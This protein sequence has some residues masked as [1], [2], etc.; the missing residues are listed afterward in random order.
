MFTFLRSIHID[1]LSFWL[2]FIAATIFWWVARS[3]RGYWPTL[4]QYV[5][6]RLEIMRQR[7]LSGLE[8]RLRR[9]TIRRAQGSHLAWSLFALDEILVEPRI[10]APPP[11]IEPG[12]AQPPDEIL[13]GTLAYL[14]DWTEMPAR[15]GAATIDLEDCLAG[16]ANIAVTGQPGSGKTVVLACIA[17]RIAAGKIIAP[18][19]E[20][21][22]PIYLHASDLSLTDLVATDPLAPIVDIYTKISPS[23]LLSQIPG[24][25]RTAVKTG[26][27]CF[28]LD[29]LDELPPAHFQSMVEYIRMVMEAYPGHRWVISASDE[30]HSGLAQLGFLPVSVASW[31]EAQYFQFVGQWSRLWM[32]IVLPKVLHQDP[33]QA[34]SPM[35]LNNWLLTQNEHRTPFEFTLKVWAAYGGDPRGLRP[36]DAIE[37]YLHRIAPKEKVRLAIER[38]AVQMISTGQVTINRGKAGSLVAEFEL[39]STPNPAE[40]AEPPPTDLP[41]PKNV[42]PSTLPPASP[43]IAKAASISRILPDLI[44]NGLIT[45]RLNETLGFMHPVILGYLA[46]CALQQGGNPAALVAQPSWIGRDL[47]LR[48]LAGQGSVANLAGSMLQDL[49]E[50]LFRNL[51]VVARWLKGSPQDAPWRGMVMRKLAEV[52][53]RELLPISVRQRALAAL[54]STNDSGLY[55]LFRQY[56]SSPS[57]SLRKLG[58]LGCGALQDQKSVAEICPLIEDEDPRVS[59]TAILVLA[60]LGTPSGLEAIL[61]VLMHGNEDMRRAVAEALARVPSIG[62]PILKEAATSQDILVR[63]ASVFGLIQVDA[64][65]ANNILE[66]MRVEDGQW[67]VRSAASQALETAQ[68]ANPRIPRPLPPPSQSPWLITYASKQGIGIS[69]GSEPTDMILEALK[70]G[71]EE[72][73]LAA[74]DYLRNKSEESI[75]GAILYAAYTETEPVREAAANALWW[76]AANGGAIPSPKKFGLS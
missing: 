37:A 73:K 27:V 62:H 68:Q 45:E 66:K 30:N 75:T 70:K 13:T 56:L 28:V 51:F 63:R 76:I 74:L 7:R 31:N 19:L 49:E 25:I 10:L 15:F 69:P 36:V 24:F 2:G 14:P 26:Q 8:G 48:Y 23:V 43:E 52:A 44:E 32:E 29:G 42:D 18:G 6:D 46:G 20:K 53:Q 58:A 40:V 65:W 71:T 5:K 72:E 35:L 50:P 4:R 33:S 38:L 61:S 3:L 60:T 11:R 12:E 17:S 54:V 57:P 64:D 59:Y 9:D 21:A 1:S 16:E 67:V 39:S 55:L 34:V 47:A 22:F 41:E